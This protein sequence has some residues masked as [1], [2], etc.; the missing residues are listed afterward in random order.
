MHKVCEGKAILSRGHSNASQTHTSKESSSD[1]WFELWPPYNH[2]TGWESGSMTCPGSLRQMREK[3]MAECWASNKAAPDMQ[4]VSFIWSLPESFTNVISSI[5]IIT[6][7]GKKI[8][9]FNVLLW[10]LEHIGQV[11]TGWM[12]DWREAAYRSQGGGNVLRMLLQPPLL[13]VASHQE[14]LFSREFSFSTTVIISLRWG[15]L[16]RDDMYF[17]LF[18][19]FSE[20][21]NDTY[22][23]GTMWYFD[24]CAHC[25]MFKSGKKNPSIS[26]NTSFLCEK[27]IEIS[28]LHFLKKTTTYI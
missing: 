28:F 7:E 12:G 19:I 8:S 23:W 9:V 25:I 5:L 10:W 14:Q 11:S 21:K 6:F 1:L 24:T 16:S 26:S 18:Y 17:F 20:H 4:A 22:L 2:H 27:H 15:Q 13:C 3:T